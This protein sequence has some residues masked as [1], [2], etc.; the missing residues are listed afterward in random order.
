MVKQLESEPAKAVDFSIS[1]L[2]KNEAIFV[3]GLLK[4]V[5]CT[6][7]PDFFRGCAG[8]PTLQEIA[9]MS[10]SEYIERHFNGTQAYLCGKLRNIIAL[11]RAEEQE[12][13]NNF[14]KDFSK[15]VSLLSKKNDEDKYVLIHDKDEF[16]VILKGMERQALERLQNNIEKIN[17]HNASI[18]SDM[19]EKLSQQNDVIKEMQD[20]IRKL[21]K[22]QQE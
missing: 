3:L 2:D 11:S 18:V 14:E 20:T 19:Q 16:E 22:N 13:S 8:G 12:V 15:R 7:C 17:K 10:D 5:P 9:L 21:K 6:H 4:P 1:Y